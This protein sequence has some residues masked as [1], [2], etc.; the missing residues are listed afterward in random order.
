MQPTPSRTPL[1]R[2]ARGSF[3]AC[4]LALIALATAG[5]IQIELARTTAHSSSERLRDY[6]VLSDLVA[7]QRRRMD[8]GGRPSLQKPGFS[9]DA[10]QTTE[11]LRDIQARSDGPESTALVR[12]RV[13]YAQALRRTG[14]EH[15]VQPL[16]EALAPLGL[17]AGR[18]QHELALAPDAAQG[19]PPIRRFGLLALTL[20][21]A[22]NL[23]WLIRRGVALL[24]R[25]IV[26][27]GR[28][29]RIEELQVQT[30]TDSLTKLGNHRAF[31]TDLSAAIE[32]RAA[33]GAHFT[34]MAID[35]DGLKRINDTK[36]HPAGDA[37]IKAVSRCLKALVANE[38]TIY[39]TGGDEF[40]VIVPNKRSWDA[41]RL[42]DEVDRATRQLAG[43]RA[44]S[45]GLTESTGLEGRQL[46]VHQADLALYEAKRTKLRAVTYRH[47]L[48]G[49]RRAARPGGTRRTT[50]EPSRPPLFA[51]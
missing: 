10:A 22:G 13:T 7:R 36:G 33:T 21:V 27:D 24:R 17:Y 16:A 46:L 6:A 3:V 41:L 47:G 32:R 44:V 40:M 30:R 29:R 2:L 9:T 4:A 45:I 31:H 48:S 18:R 1:A 37:H 49:G 42:A 12:L 11:I 23:L 43:A 26:R 51:R 38:G 5:T 14:S 34:L 20:V 35:L 19:D 50:G 15:Q 39:R 8:V 25:P 28:D